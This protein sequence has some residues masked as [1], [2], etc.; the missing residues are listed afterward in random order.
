[1]LRFWTK[2]K[3]HSPSE[4]WL[5]TASRNSDGYGAFRIH[6]ETVGAHR[7]AYQEYAGKLVSIVELDHL[8]KVRHCVNPLHLEQVSHRENAMRARENNYNAKKTHCPLKHKYSDSNTYIAGTN[9]QCRTCKNA[10]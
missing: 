3:K 7:Y 2:V 6:G 1:M 4:C 10:R 8:C 5:W 9:R